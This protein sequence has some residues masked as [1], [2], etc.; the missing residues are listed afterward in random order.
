MKH[1]LTAYNLSNSSHI[2]VFQGLQAAL[3]HLFYVQKFVWGKI[4]ILAIQK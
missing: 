2:T 1:L 3:G 4:R